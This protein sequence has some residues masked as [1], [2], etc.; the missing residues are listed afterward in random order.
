MIYNYKIV[1][2]IKDQPQY[3]FKMMFE[4]EADN[5]KDAQKEGAKRW[6]EKQQQRSRLLNAD[7]IKIICRKKEEKPRT[8]KATTPIDRALAAANAYLL[9][10]INK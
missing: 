3:R 5:N 8:R 4:I 2:K 10:E 9:S 6:T 1:F 7:V